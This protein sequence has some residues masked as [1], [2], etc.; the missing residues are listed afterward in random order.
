[1]LCYPVAGT[2]SDLH[3]LH[4]SKCEFDPVH[5]CC[6]VA[7]VNLIRFLFAAR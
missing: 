3:L 2:V 6:T 1:M 4:G 5:V 7:N